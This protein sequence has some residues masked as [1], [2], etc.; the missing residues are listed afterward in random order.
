M[1]Y[2]EQLQTVCLSQTQNDIH[3]A[4]Q[5]AA[6][7]AASPQPTPLH[8]LYHLKGGGQTDDKEDLHPCFLTH[9]HCRRGEQGRER[10]AS[11]LHRGVRLSGY[12]YWPRTEATCKQSI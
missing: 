8:F 5:E 6:R 11:V 4:E 3:F 7:S 12:G 9:K 1:Y 2:G 10:T